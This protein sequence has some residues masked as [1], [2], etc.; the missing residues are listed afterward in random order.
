MKIAA[1]IPTYNHGRYISTAVQSVLSQTRPLDDVIVVD[2]GS[3]DD[4]RVRLEA[5]GSRVRYVRQGN[6]GLSA[7]RNTGI[8]ATHCEWLAF[9]DADD[10]WLPDKVRLQQLELQTSPSA[11]LCYTGVSYANA[12]GEVS[13]RSPPV[14]PLALWP[15][16]RY[17]NAIRGGGSAVC[18]RRD[19][20]LDAEGFDESLGACEDWDMWVRLA[21]LTRFVAVNEPVT[22]VRLAPTSMSSS[23]ERMLANAERILESTLLGSLSGWRRRAWRRRIRSAQL[24]HASVS[25][26][27][28]GPAREWQFLSRSLRQWPVPW[29]LPVR[30]RALLLHLHAALKA[31][32]KARRANGMDRPL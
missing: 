3:T 28:E 6:R 16:L 4:T 10:W 1:I 9:L 2:D 13:R 25:A 18:V 31:R 21:R 5:F 8:R 23:P 15:Q 19:L 20:V 29:F 7:A 27:E 12:A 14:A 17:R 22:V 11:G 30:Y 32:A 24:F 26:R